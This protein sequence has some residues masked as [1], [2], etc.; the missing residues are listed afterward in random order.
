MQRIHA[1]EQQT[2]NNIK[3]SRLPASIT[4]ITMRRFNWGKNLFG[5]GSRVDIRLAHNPEHN[6]G[7]ILR[8]ARVLGVRLRL[9][10]DKPNQGG[11]AR[12]V[13]PRSKR[14]SSSRAV[15]INFR[16]H[17]IAAQRRKLSSGG[18]V[19]GGKRFA[20]AAPRRVELHKHVLVALNNWVEVLKV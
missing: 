14:P 19:F 13:E 1:A 17:G 16:N 12:H 10:I 15:G 11:I 9:A 4:A 6:V 8:V 2:K 7:A 20:E 18:G 5:Q 3:S